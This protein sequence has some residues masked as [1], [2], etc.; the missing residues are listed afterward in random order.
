M[1]IV[2]CMVGGRR[3]ALEYSPRTRDMSAL[4]EQ[5]STGSPAR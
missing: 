4:T 5:S 1:T 2:A 3:D